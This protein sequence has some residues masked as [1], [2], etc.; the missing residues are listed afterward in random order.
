MLFNSSFAQNKKVDH[1]E[2][3]TS[4]Y[5]N[6]PHCPVTDGLTMWLLR[7]N[8]TLNATQTL[9]KTEVPLGN[10][11]NYSKSRIHFESYIPFIK[12]KSFSSMIGVNYH[13]ASILSED[14]NDFNKSL[15]YM[16]AWIILRY[17]LNNWLFNVSNEIYARGDNNSF[18]K[19]TGNEIFPIA[20]VA[21]AFNNKWQII[22]MTAY[23]LKF[24]EEGKKEM[25]MLGIQG[26]YIASNRFKIV[27]GAPVLCAFD[28]NFL[29][30]F[31]LSFKQ[32][33]LDRTEAYLR[34]NITNK[35]GI[36]LHY[37]KYDHRSKDTYF[38]NE[39][40]IINNNEVIYNNLSQMQH[41]ISLELGVKTFKNIG[42]FFT[43]GYNLGKNISL[44]NNETF[45]QKTNGKHEFFI[46]LHLQYL[47]KL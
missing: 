42:A 37:N 33:L 20:T 35:I 1:W 44:Y 39:I 26:K 6:E 9:L 32:L 2:F 43:G 3:D 14:N 13:K 11:S 8:L 10:N 29:P 46:G 18:Y 4:D 28:W 5:F 25:P 38:A 30:D 36:S 34:Y 22:I 31:D 45:L 47:N 23:N 19:K 17:R 16:W 40:P 12:H 21:Y 7:Q 41:S 27:F 24:M 15:N